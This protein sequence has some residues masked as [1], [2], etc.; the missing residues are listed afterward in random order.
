MILIIGGSKEGNKRGNKEGRE[1]ASQFK[2]DL[3]ED[4]GREGKETA[5]Q[6]RRRREGGGEEGRAA[7]PFHLKTI[8]GK[9]FKPRRAFKMTHVSY[10]GHGTYN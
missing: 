5:S 10:S 3:R 1:Q 2:D 4:S 9:S 6:L 7:T 8:F